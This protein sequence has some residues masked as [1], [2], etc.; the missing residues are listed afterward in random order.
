M[1][2]IFARIANGEI[3]SYKIAETENCFAFFRFETSSERSYFNYPK[4]GD[5]LYF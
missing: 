4:A 2:G 5:R 1:A 3:P